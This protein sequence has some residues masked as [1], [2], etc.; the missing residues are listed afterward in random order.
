MTSTSTTT[1]STP[2]TK[3]PSSSS[4]F[5][6]IGILGGGQLGRMLCLAAAN[7]GIKCMVL[8]PA[9]QPSAGV[10]STAVQGSFRDSNTIKTFAQHVDILTIEIEHVDTTSLETLV[11]ENNVEVQPSPQTIAIIQDKFIQ[12]QHFKNSNVP[13]GE[14][15]D[16]PNKQE[17]QVAIEKYGYPLMLKSKCLA[18]DGR[19][20][21]VIKT[22]QDIDVAVLKLG[23]YEKGLYVEKWQY[24]IKELAVMVI[25]SR[26]GTIKSYPVTETIQKDNICH[27]TETPAS[28]SVQATRNAQRLA[29]EAVASLQGAGIFGVEMFLLDDGK[30]VLLNEVAP[31]VHNS[32]HYTI[33]GCV[34]SQFE[35]HIRALLGWP[36]GDTSL[37]TGHAIMLNILGEG[38]TTVEGE[39]IA[40]QLIDK[41]LAT[42]GCSVHWYDKHGGVTKGRKVG[43]INIVGHTQQE[44]RRRLG[45]LNSDALT[46]LQQSSNN[47]SKLL[48]R[49]GIIMGSDSDLSTMKAAAQV[50]EVEFGI[51]V[52]VTIVSAHRT[53]ERLVS[54][55]R[56]A[57]LRGI[58][59]II[60]GA[61][62]AA[63]LPGMVAAM[64]PLPV[65]GVPVKPTG[66]HLDGM[67]A[68]Y[69]IVQMPKGV[70]VATV[71]IGNATNAGLLACRILGI[72]DETL[73]NKMID[74]QI[75]M[76]D[77]VLKKADMLEE[78]GW[79]EY[80]LV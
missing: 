14:F 72:E 37:T 21:Y 69:S 27:V 30:T 64:T 5:P 42:P 35:N 8:D 6:T 80:E 12:K 46:S 29:C 45:M 23:G 26:D 4:S 55:A 47:R 33:D 28:V 24:F 39:Q 38:E 58:K 16:I 75:T 76:R 65:I 43:H 77:V 34:T 13:V 31:R 22:E 53:P 18:Y 44:T 20:N 57:H 61:G 36:L 52:E 71:A 11:Q 3:Q 74:Y 40:K 73:L 9:P 56:S 63:H 2:T 19:G 62:G 54:Y 32:G 78:K 51:P 67:D 59:V 15:M 41:A 79:K 66:A 68:L 49:V 50:L 25:R 7:L 70:P 17:L 10:A 60:A 1:V 48:P